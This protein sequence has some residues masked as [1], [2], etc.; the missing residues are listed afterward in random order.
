MRFRSLVRLVFAL[1]LMA[2]ASKPAPVSTSPLSQ[3]PFKVLATVGNSGSR[4]YDV[5]YYEGAK[6]SILGEITGGS[7]VT[8]QLPGEGRGSVR[9]FGAQGDGGGRP[10]DR[11]VRIRIHCAGS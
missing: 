7:T 2:C 11:T 1:P 9:L 5:Y 4:S 8:Y 10:P 3:C 6:R